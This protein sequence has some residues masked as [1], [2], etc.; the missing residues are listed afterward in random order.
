M[1][2]RKPDCRLKFLNKTTEEKGE[3]GA[4]WVNPDGSLT[5]VLNPMVVLKQDI[6]LVYTIFPQGK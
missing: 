5:L 2:G 3:V 6:N 4:L 1:K